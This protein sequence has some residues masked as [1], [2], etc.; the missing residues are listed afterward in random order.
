M[1]ILNG[2]TYEDILICPSYSEISSRSEVSLKSKLTKGMN[3]YY[4]V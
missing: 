3:S 2:Y 4:F 1:K